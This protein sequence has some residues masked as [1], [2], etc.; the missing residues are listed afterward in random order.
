MIPAYS[1]YDS[2]VTSGPYRSMRIKS[3][4]FHRPVGSHVRVLRRNIPLVH[5]LNYLDVTSDITRKCRIHIETNKK[6]FGTLKRV[7]CRF[8]SGG[9]SAKIK[10]TIHE[11][12]IRSL[13]RLPRLGIFG[14]NSSPEVAAPTKLRFPQNWQLSKAHTGS[15]LAYGFKAMC[16]RHP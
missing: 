11:A 12:L 9:L 6:N 5:R 15:R 1:Q 13:I 10:L 8:T 4:Q 2:C 16:C 3:R 14:R 7:R